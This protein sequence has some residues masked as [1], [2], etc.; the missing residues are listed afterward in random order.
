MA[1]DRTVGTAHIQAVEMPC[2]ICGNTIDVGEAYVT[3]LII[4]REVVVC[5]G[6]I[7]V[8]KEYIFQARE[9]NTPPIPIH[10]R[11]QRNE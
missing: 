8:W 7:D 5:E 6:C 10:S 9:L 11:E 1:T 2:D 4:D 3:P